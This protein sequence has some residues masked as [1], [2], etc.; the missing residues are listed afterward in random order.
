MSRYRGPRVKLLRRLGMDLPGL[1]PKSQSR[2]AY[3]PGEHGAKGTRR[4]KTE[5]AL[6]LLEKQKVRIN[7]GL[8]ERQLRKLVK[9]ANRMKGDTGL[10]ILRLLEQR[11]DNVVFRMGVGRSIPHAR[12]VV[13]HGHVL[14][15]GR[16]VNIPSFRVKPG[17]EISLSEKLLNNEG[18]KETLARPALARP[19][20]IKFEN[21]KALIS[22]LPSRTDVPFEVQENLIV[23]YYAPRV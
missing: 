17:M 11:L 18:V 22:E 14:I 1:T 7:Y 20:Y 23:E 10:N 5:F 3:P 19:S 21:N 2:R 6:H 12:Q 15:N 16:R 13:T 8:S 4:K 9:D